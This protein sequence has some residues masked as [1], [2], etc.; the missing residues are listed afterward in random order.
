M[1]VTWH[2]KARWRLGLAL[3]NFRIACASFFAGNK[4]CQRIVLAVTVC[5]PAVNC[6]PTGIGDDSAFRL[7]SLLA[8]PGDPGSNLKLGGREKD[9]NEPPGHQVEYLLLGLIQVP[10]GLTG[11]NDR[12]VIC[13]LRIVKNAF[14]RA[15][16]S[17][18][19]SSS[20]VRTQCRILYAGEYLFRGFEIVLRQV[21]RIGSR[22]G[23]QF[24]SLVE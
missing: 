7:E 1:R 15:H 21:A 19:K 20:S 24:I 12:V 23:D 13:D 2:P 11:R 17:A 18:P 16:P 14:A 5:L 8:Y 6:Q 10:G 4:G 3:D 9:G 22:V